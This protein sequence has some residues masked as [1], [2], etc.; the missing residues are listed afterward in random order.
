[1]ESWIVFCSRLHC[2][3]P[4][5]VAYA[6]RLDRLVRL[7]PGERSQTK[8]RPNNNLLQVLTTIRRSTGERHASKRKI[9]DRDSESIQLPPAM[10][11]L[12]NASLEV[13]HRFCMLRCNFARPTARDRPRL[14]GLDSLAA[15]TTDDHESARTEH[16][17]SRAFRDTSSRVSWSPTCFAQPLQ[18]NSNC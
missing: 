5:Y 15:M 7:V 2:T 18:R 3:P 1:M 8:L 13:Y 9:W 6:C 16:N 11:I 10:K 4:R 14:S 12:K 17:M